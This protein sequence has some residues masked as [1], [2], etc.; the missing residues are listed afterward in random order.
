MDKSKITTGP[1]FKTLISFA[2]PF[3]MVNL[4]QRLFHVADVAILGIMATDADVAAVGACGSIIAMMVCLFAGYSSAANVVVAKRVGAQDEYRSRRAT[5]TALILGFVSGVILMVIAF[6]FARDILILT[7][8]QEDVLDMATLYMKIYFAGMPVMM[9]Y[10]FVAALLR[11]TGDSVRPMIYMMISGVANVGLNVVFVG[12]FN[13]AVAGVALATVFSNVIALVLGLIAL[14]KNKDYC[15]IER[16]HLRIYKQEFLE[17]M[18]IGFPTCI[19]G[20]GFYLGEVIVVAMVNSIST[21]AMTANTI[22]SQVDV[23]VYGVGSSIATATGIM[24]SQNLGA[25]KLDR[26]SSLVK[27]GST[28]VITVTLSLGVIAV[29]LAPFVFG[30]MTDNPDVIKLALGRSVFVCLTNFITCEME[31]FSNAIRAMKRP[32]WLLF[33]GIVCGFGIRTVWALFIW[34]LYPEFF[35][36]FVALPLSTLVGTLIFLPVYLRAMKEHRKSF[37]EAPELAAV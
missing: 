12:I 23:L 5:G 14:A 30:I 20:I 9:L 27:I 8:C 33:G 1:L 6:I 17:M 29:L 37:S 18:K 34:P 4:V 19:Q 25:K 36:L 3:I 28:L 15:K 16:K 31:V 10:N 24:I 32:N 11:A 35:F 7:K 2:I 22:A 26:V 21:N 13:L